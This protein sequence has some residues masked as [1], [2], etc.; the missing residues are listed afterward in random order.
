MVFDGRTVR[1]EEVSEVRAGRSFAIVMDTA[2]CD[3]AVELARGVDLLLCEAT[4]LESE[5]FLARDYGHLTAREAATIA[6]EAD[7]GQLVL[8]H[9]SA[10]YPDLSGHLQEATEVF[11]DVVVA[12]DL[13]VV[14]MRR[15]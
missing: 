15:H 2:A 9:F 11:D 10:R 5:S 6:R 12:S 14:P 13:Q 3:A 8:T 1:L 7:V 4:F